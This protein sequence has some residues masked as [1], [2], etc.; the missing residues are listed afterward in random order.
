MIHARFPCSN[1]HKGIER[2]GLPLFQT[3]IH[4]VWNDLF[5]TLLTAPKGRFIAIFF[6]VYFVVV[7]AVQAC[8]CHKLCPRPF[9]QYLAFAL[10]YI[11]FPGKCMHDLA[12]D[13]PASRDFG[14]AFWF[15]FNTASTIGYSGSL[16]PNPDW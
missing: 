11:M 15:S 10:I 12:Y 9:L 13:A 5:T 2:F 1:P 6:A 4:Y 8:R 14:H 16:A 7:S 3:F